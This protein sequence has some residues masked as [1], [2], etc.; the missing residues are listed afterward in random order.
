MNALGTLISD[1]ISDLPWVV[2]WNIVLFV[3]LFIL[4][5]VA[6]VTGWWITGAVC[7][8]L[9]MIAAVCAGIGE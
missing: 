2:E 5:F 8:V 9:A 1:I 7:F 3:I 6:C 4:M